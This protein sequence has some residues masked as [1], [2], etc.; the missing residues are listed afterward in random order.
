MKIELSVGTALFENDKL[1]IVWNKRYANCPNY[2]IVAN[3]LA[4]LIQELHAIGKSQPDEIE[5]GLIEIQNQFSDD[6]RYL[7]AAVCRDARLLIGD[8]TA[9]NENLREIIQQIGKM[10]A[11]QRKQTED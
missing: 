4:S 9:K 6:G 10:K 2:Y 1:V 5:D 3:E 8:I 7:E 11:N